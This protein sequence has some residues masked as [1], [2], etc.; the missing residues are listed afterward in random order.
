MAKS[1]SDLQK[2]LES[3]KEALQYWQNCLRDSKS[4]LS[5][6]KAAQVTNPLEEL[7]KLAKLIRAHTTKVG[8]VFKPET[9]S[10][11]TNAAYDT[12][13]KLSESLVLIISILSQ[14]KA[15]EISDMFYSEILHTVGLLIESNSQF[16]DELAD[17]EA[18]ANQENENSEVSK[19]KNENE[20]DGRLVSVGKIWS[21]CDALTKLL[22]DGE[23]GLLSK[24]IKQSITLIEDGLDEFEEW[25]ENPDDFD[26][27]DD[28]FGFSDDE[29]EDDLDAPPVNNTTET[30][31]TENNKVLVDFAQL[32][33]SKFK[34]I[35]LLLISIT[36]SLP[37][38]T[39]GDVINKTYD[40]QRLIVHKIDKLIVDLMLNKEV[41]DECKLTAEDIAKI[42]YRLVKIVK[43]VNKSSENKVKWCVAW[44]SKFKE[45]L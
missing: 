16:A 3:F 45:G 41:D 1:R 38:V 9:L 26:L 15:D 43:D 31:Q 22:N 13:L 10:K 14:L 17:M 34:L 18:R 28:P 7:T 23:L 30:E 32:W 44:D 37:S 36:R 6:I 35:K 27:D 8:I 12:L 24:K 40:N 11:E 2:L 21:N 25:A 33:L 42:C 20:I 19:S 4:S 5:D 29:S 39:S